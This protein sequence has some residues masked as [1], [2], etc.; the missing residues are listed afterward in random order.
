[1]VNILLSRDGA[2]RSLPA[3]TSPQIMPTISCHCR[4]S[5]SLGFVCLLPLF[6]FGVDSFAAVLSKPRARS[7][8]PARRQTA[9]APIHYN[10]QKRTPMF[11]QLKV[12]DQDPESEGKGPKNTELPKIEPIIILEQQQDIGNPSLPGW[13]RTRR[14]RRRQTQ[15]Q[16]RQL[17]TWSAND[18]PNRPIICEYEPDASWLWTRWR[19]TVL[20]LTIVPVVWNIGV[21]IVV[22]AAIHYQINHYSLVSSGNLVLPTSLMHRTWPL[23]AIP[24]QDDPLIQ[25]L[26]GLNSLWEYQV[27]LTTFILTFFTA[28]AYKHWRTVYLTTR[29][30]QG[31]INDMCLLL[32]IAAKRDDPDSQA[33]VATCTRLLKK[34]HS[35]FW[36]AMPTV[37]D[38]LGDVGIVNDDDS[39]PKGPKL[40]QP[41]QV[42]PLLL[43]PQGLERLVQSK[44]L[45][46]EERDALLAS[47]LPPSQY[48]YVLMEWVGLYVMEGLE[49]G[50]LLGPRHGDTR[51][52]NIPSGWEENFLRQLTALR[53]EYFN[54]GDYVSGRMPLAYVQLVQVLVD[55]LVYIAPLSLYSELG[56]LSIP[57]TG[58]LTLFYKGLLELSKSFLDPFGVEGFPGQNI[59]V[60]VLVSELNFGA[61]RRWTKAA[62][63]FP[64][65]PGPLRRTSKGSGKQ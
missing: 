32:T 54:I 48:T 37:S 47:G 34:S 63:A 42:G 56:T 16:L 33:L 39:N 65:P 24:P 13:T 49:A 41:D 26:A 58:L 40:E 18:Q 52:R 62:Q 15:A 45:R 17:A 53:G 14:Q 10:I 46:P 51:N 28:E 25:Q 59:R 22:D 50:F 60:D 55:S 8:A 43:T 29:A 20:S 31:R 9:N 38:G 44:E 3:K 61:A 12:D 4:R 2:A 5:K 6:A 1:M 11:P 30:I 21:G 7:T 23:L 35:F 19:G 64:E 36:A 27:T 57:L